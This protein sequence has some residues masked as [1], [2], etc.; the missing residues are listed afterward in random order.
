VIKYKKQKAS[1]LII[2][3][4]II[5]ISIVLVSV[6]AGNSRLSA[7]I[8]MHQQDALKDWADMLTTINLAKMEIILADASSKSGAFGGAKNNVTNK[9]DKQLFQ[10]QKIKLSYPSNENMIVRIYDLSGKINLSTIRKD[11]FKKLIVAKIGR[12]TK[13]VDE[14]LDAWQ[15]WIDDDN[16]KKLN[17]AEKSYYNKLQPPYSPRNSA[18]QSVNELNL[19]KG[20]RDVFGDYDYS[21]IFT[22]FGSRGSQLNPN[23]ANKQTLLL[24][25]GIDETLASE[26]ISKRSEKEFATMAEFNALIPAEVAGQVRNWFTLSRSK[27]Y[28]LIIYSKKTEQEA[29]TDN[30]GKTGIYVYKEIIQAKGGENKPK[31]LRVFPSYK[32]YL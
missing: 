32:I 26:I 28:E 8:V 24:I 19:I 7:T 18:L 23:I 22:L 29:S 31:T 21:Q 12:E 4:W 20:F 6:L 17:G 14:L 15:D 2:V 13:Q 5:S 1:I 11:K 30:S 27:F 3:L 10:G 25:P 16:L 9:K